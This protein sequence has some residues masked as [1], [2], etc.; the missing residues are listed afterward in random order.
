MK[1]SDKHI[2][3]SRLFIYYNGREKDGNCYE[4]NGTTI[5]SAVEALEQLGCCEES[6]WPYD[7]TMVSQKLT[8]Q[9]YKEAMRYRV[10]EKI[11]VDTEL[12]A[13]KACLAQ[14]YPFVFGIQLFESFSQADSPETKGKVPL[15]QENEKD[16]SNDYGWHAMLAVGYSDRSRCFIVRNSYGGK[17]GDNGYCYIPYDYM[18]N[19]KLCLDAHSLR[20]FS[21]DRDNS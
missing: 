10:S 17:W 9:A 13:M 19:P 1:N 7:P 3:V 2:D 4:D 15:P 16:G 18:S 14:G 5:V 6:T 11:S 20:A 21:D 8:E 12:N